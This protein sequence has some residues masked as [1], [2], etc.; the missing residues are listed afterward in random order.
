MADIGRPRKY[1]TSDVRKIIDEYVAFTGGTVLLDASKVARYAERNLDLKMFKYYDITRNVEIKKYIGDLNSAIVAKEEKRITSSATAVTQIDVMAYLSMNK[2]ELKQAL[3][4]INVLIE[5]IADSNTKLLKEV[6]ILQDRIR[7]QD[8]QIKKQSD[9][10][11]Q[12]N[13]DAEKRME[14]LKKTIR[15]QRAIVESL[16]RS[17]KVR[18]NTLHLLWDKESELVL[19][20]MGLLENNDQRT[21]SKNI[22]DVAQK[23]DLVID[24]AHAIGLDKVSFAF[25]EKLKKI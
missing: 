2:V 15:E 1:S 10:L 8:I 23:T 6:I 4:N 18:D 13:K 12:A 11:S 24:D 25:M 16:A 14:S 9:M 21:D 5:D 7:G 19:K 17:V 20:Q 3:I 22:M